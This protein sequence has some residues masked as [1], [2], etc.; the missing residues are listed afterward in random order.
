MTERLTRQEIIMKMPRKTAAN[1]VKCLDALERR[2]GKMFK[3]IFKSITVDNGGEFMDTDGIERSCRTKGKRTT[4][5]YC[6]PYSS[7][8]RGSNEHANS[9]IRRFIPKG[10]SI[11]KYTPAQIKK[12]ET[13]MNRYPRKILNYECSEDVFMRHIA[14]I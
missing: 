7:W 13:W 8:E 2:C 5:Y 4:L 1:T 3:K 12:I 9:L 10:T 14:M 11:D 6:H